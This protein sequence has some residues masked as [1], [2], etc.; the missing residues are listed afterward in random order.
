MEAQYDAFVSYSTKDSE[1]VTALRLSLEAVGRRVWQDVKELELTHEWWAQIKQGI[2]SADN[3]VMVVSPMSMS[4]PVCHLEI[5]H[6]RYLKKRVIIILHSVAQKE[7]TIQHMLERISSQDYLKTITQG[8]N[9]RQVAQV[10]WLA[11]EGEQNV[12]ITQKEDIAVKLNILTEAFDKDLAYVRQHTRLGER[13]REWERDGRNAS[14]LLFGDALI[15]AEKWLQDG[16]AK[17]PIP[18]DL[19][20]AYISTSRQNEDTLR[21]QQQARERLIRQFRWASGVLGIVGVLAIGAT[22]FA[23]SQVQQATT[24]LVTVTIAQGQAVDGQATAIAQQ[25]NAEQQAITATVAQGQAQAQA[26]LAYQQQATAQQDALLA[27]AQVATATVQQGQ[28]QA[29]ATVA[30]QQQATAQQDAL[31]AQAQVATATVQ[32]GQAQ[33]EATLAYQQQATA[34]QDALLAQAQASTAT[35]QVATAVAIQ[36]TAQQQAN[37]AQDLVMTA[38]LAQGQAQASANLAQTQVAGAGATLTQIPP[39]LTQAAIINEN[40]LI[41][42]DIAFTFADVALSPS[43]SPLAIIAVL[44]GLVAKYPDRATA[45]Q[46]RG[47][48]YYQQGSYEQ[49]IADFTQAIS[50]EP[51]FDE[52]YSNRA[53]A[54][55]AM[56]DYEKA[57]EDF[58]IVLQIRPNDSQSLVNRGLIYKQMGLSAEAIADYSQ[59]IELNSNDAVAYYNRAILYD[60]LGQDLLAIAD[61]SRAIEIDPLLTEAY[62]NR[63]TLYASGELDAIAIGD[64]SMALQLNPNYVP[65][66]I[67]R[68]V[69]YMIL[70]DYELAI[71]DFTIAIAK[72]TDDPYQYADLYW[73]RG[74]AYYLIEEYALAVAD[75][76]AWEALG[77]RLSGEFADYY[78]DAK[79]KSR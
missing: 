9:M 51:D 49:A 47:L 79:A 72:T 26:T 10:N 34:Q 52:A 57:L 69:S 14:F 18:D 8:R 68:G 55:G 48:A 32:Q 40:A 41:E 24:Q 67:N 70:Q 11:V 16:T 1:F 62:Y 7:V 45:Y 44:N 71:D 17:K 50:I 29:E 42:Q 20:R 78:Q 53:L 19:H 66:Y 59:A 77:F 27:Q 30:Y 28:A 6:A 31:L 15:S 63:G 39:T 60:E 75:W 25:A 58:S 38:T 73:I 64:Y 36:N 12:V 35:A 21:Q 74:Y 46:V 43:S 76:D 33:A 54:Y 5:E 3:F 23:V 4:S 56:G 65:A 22:L 13:A 37:R 2:E 61:Y